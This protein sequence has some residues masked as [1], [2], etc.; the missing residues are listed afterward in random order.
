MR[1]A[2]HILGFMSLGVPAMILHECGHIVTAKVCGVK[3]KKVGVSRLGLYTVREPGPPRLNLI[4]SLAGPLANLLLAVVL[5]PVLP[6]FAQVN[7]IAGLFNLVPLQNSDGDRV[8]RILTNVHT[9]TD[10]RG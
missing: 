10:G 7:L 8:M 1:A 3:V 6:S 5:W 4:V 2:A 9:N